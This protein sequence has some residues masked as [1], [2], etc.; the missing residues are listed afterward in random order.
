MRLRKGIR[1]HDGS[2][3]SAKDVVASLNRFLAVTELGKQAARDLKSLKAAVEHTV[4]L[5]LER[6]RYSIL[7]EL[8]SPDAYVFKADIV[9]NVA[10]TGFTGEQ[11][12]GTGPYK[13]KSWK[14]GQEIVLEKFDGY[15][16]RSEENWGGFAGAKHAYLQ[17]LVFPIVRDAN[18]QVIGL[19][20]GRFDFVE[21]NIDQYDVLKSDPKLVVDPLAGA[22]LNVFVV[23]QSPGA[24]FANVKARRAL[25]L[26]IDR[27]AI[28]A[29]MGANKDIVENTPAYVIKAIKHMCAV[30]DMPN[31]VAEIVGG[32]PF[33]RS[34]TLGIIFAVYL[35]GGTF[36][37]DLAFLILA[38][39]IFWPAM[40][41]LGYDP[42]WLCITMSVV[43]GIGSIIP[44]MAI[45]VFIVRQITGVPIG[46]IYRGVYPF[47]IS[48]VLCLALLF[49]FPQ[50]V[51][52]LPSV[53]MP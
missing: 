47:L 14:P 12:I 25:C 53:T 24:L 9:A 20:S 45:C 51:L 19:K 33:E 46:V 50:L 23:N 16:S 40:I 11:S 5:T 42:I 36:M 13:L 2:A 15:A 38:T 32:L 3:L 10:A 4:V 44:P 6:P 48:L 17:T 49:A 52:Y 8:A 18:A 31:Q 41:N 26:L 30:T 27:Q 34:V 7:S 39:P 28:G 1:F 22:N 29:A 37:D 35:V 43:L 21:P